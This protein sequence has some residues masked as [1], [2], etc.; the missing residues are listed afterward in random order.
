MNVILWHQASTNLL[1][2]YVLVRS[3]CVS[4][5]LWFVESKF[6]YHFIILRYVVTTFDVRYVETLYVLQKDNKVPINSTVN[7]S[8]RLWNAL[9]YR[10]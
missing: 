2:P 6:P 8:V 3:V 9:Y 7:S 1:F 4:C 10:C 5:K